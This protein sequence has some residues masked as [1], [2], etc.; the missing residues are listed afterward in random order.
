MAQLLDRAAVESDFVV[1]GVPADLASELLDAF[2]ETKRRFHLGDFRP[3]AVEGGRFSEAALR[4]L[5]WQTTGSYTPLSDPQFKAD[6]VL[7]ALPQLAPGSFPESVRIHLPRALRVIYDIR[8]KRDAAHLNDSIDPNLQDASIVV[9]ILDWSLAELV[10]LHH[11]VS[12]A[13]AQQI[14]DSLVRREVPMIQEF[15]GQPRILKKLGHK[16]HVI[17][18]LYWW[19][20]RP[21]DR[22]L[23]SSWLPPAVRRN[24]GR[25]LDALHDDFLVT[26]APNTAHITQLGMRFVEDNNL[27]SPL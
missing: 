19:G 18:L 7:N 3:N 14:I 24:P 1:A 9:S 17:V 12:A 8:N 11:N 26:V 25:V 5:E 2:V 21:L 13:D 10:R 23:L 6:R 27:I 22:K 4:V 16:E 20:D 15:N